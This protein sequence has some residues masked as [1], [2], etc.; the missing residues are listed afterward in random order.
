[1]AYKRSLVRPSGL[2]SGLKDCKMGMPT[3]ATSAM[4]GSAASSARL[5]GGSEAVVMISMVMI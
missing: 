5:M 3:G 1:M 4:G 2:S